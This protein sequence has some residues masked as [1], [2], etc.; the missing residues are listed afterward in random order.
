[1]V[2]TFMTPFWAVFWRKAVAN[3]STRPVFGARGVDGREGRICA[4][5]LSAW[6]FSLF[7][8]CE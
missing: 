7:G 1:M 4:K 6:I 8:G 3:L 2:D 5:P